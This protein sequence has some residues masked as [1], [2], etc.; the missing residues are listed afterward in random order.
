MSD[1]LNM[2][3]RIS[4]FF[5]AHYCPKMLLC[6][7][8]YACEPYFKNIGPR[9]T[10]LEQVAILRTA[11]LPFYE[12]I[13]DCFIRVDDCFIRVCDRSIRVYQFLN[14]FACTVS[15]M[16]LDFSARKKSCN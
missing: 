10:F 2:F 13:G 16:Y 4:F 8:I 1:L 9:S 14:F 3:S 5:L 15:V 6:S 7:Y 11:L 12:N